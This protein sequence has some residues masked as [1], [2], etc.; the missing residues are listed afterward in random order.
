MIEKIQ[1]NGYEFQIDREQPWLRF[2]GSSPKAAT[3][4]P[5]PDPSPTPQSLWM[6]L[7]MLELNPPP[8][9]FQPP[10]KA[11][12]SC[13]LRSNSRS[14]VH[15]VNSNTPHSAGCCD[16]K[17]KQR[18]KMKKTLLITLVSVAAI[19]AQAAL[20]TNE[21]TSVPS[22]GAI[23]SHLTA[24]GTEGN[25]EVSWRSS[26]VHSLSGQSFLSTTTDTAMGL[27]L[28]VRSTET[29]GNWTSD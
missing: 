17:N 3:P 9:G 18:E 15:F 16:V 25:R 11:S 21:G 22:A 14:K 6:P 5:A 19:G 10:P 29:W 20:I 23:A 28:K 4:P 13:S 12:S 27:T 7:A 26:A 24:A 1:Y 8:T 2:K